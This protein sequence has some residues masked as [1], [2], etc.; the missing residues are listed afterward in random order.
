MKKK[1][2]NRTAFLVIGSPRSGTSFLSKVLSEHG[3]YFGEKKLFIDPLKIPINPEFLELKSVNNLNDLI[4]KK[5]KFNYIDFNFVPDVE[6][7]KINDKSKIHEK[8]RNII[9]NELKNKDLIGIKDPRISFTLPLWRDNLLKLNYK[10]IVIVCFRSLEETILSNKK[11]NNLPDH[12]N[13]LIPA[14][15]YLSII[16]LMK[17]YPDFLFVNYNQLLNSRFSD[18]NNILKNVQIKFKKSIFNECINSNFIRNKS[19]NED[20]IFYNFIKK[21]FDLSI[22]TQIINALYLKSTISIDLLKK[23]FDVIRDKNNLLIEENKQ[24][25]KEFDVIRDKN[26]LLIEENKQQKKEFDVI[27]DKN[28]LLIEENK[29]LRNYFEKVENLFL[30]KTIRFIRNFIK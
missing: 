4:L 18:L 8:I 7:I 25:K 12:T 30:I 15:H 29:Q 10:V 3:I 9:N 1:I 22:F 19:N 26:N 28:N 24:Q 23:E 21:N 17:K 14:I 20:N 13:T 16:N 2:Q 27:R 11:S 5:V 6:K